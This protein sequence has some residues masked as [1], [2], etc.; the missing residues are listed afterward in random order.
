MFWLSTAVVV[1][2]VA[3]VVWFSRTE[4][5]TKRIAIDAVYGHEETLDVYLTYSSC[6]EVDRIDAAEDASTVRLSAYVH[7]LPSPTCGTSP[8]SKRTVQVVL[9][10]P[11]A[12]R[13]VVDSATGA[14][15]LVH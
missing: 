6:D 5:T 15:V 14:S 4:D 2:V 12:K 11:L 9:R 3:A 8:I 10:R 7:D 13:S 1:V